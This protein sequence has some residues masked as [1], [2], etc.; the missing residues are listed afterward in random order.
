MVC[1]NAGHEYPVLKRGNGDYELYKQK[2][3][4]ALAVMRDAKFREYE[5]DLEPGD[6][7]FVYTDGIPE[8][9]NNSQEAY[10]T[11]RLLDVLNRNK[12]LPQKNILTQTTR[13]IK[14]FVGEEEQFDDVTMMG[15]K[16]NGPAK[17]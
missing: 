14:Y 10:G 15:F 7:L 13:D 11:D 12:D 5:L 3:N 1:A 9:I 8:A 6:S 16:Y 4:I 2:H 17:T